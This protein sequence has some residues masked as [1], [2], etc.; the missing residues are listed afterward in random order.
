MNLKDRFLE[1]YKNPSDRWMVLLIPLIAALI[2]FQSCAPSTVKEADPT[3]Y[4][5]DSLI[6]K[7]YVLIPVQL[8]NHQSIESMVGAQSIVNIYAVKPGQSEGQ[9]LGRNLRMVRAPLN[10]QQFAVLVPESKVSRFMSQQGNLQAV[11]QNKV[12]DSSSEVT[13]SYSKKTIQY[14]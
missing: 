4:E 2:V 11:L 7:G 6:P 3:S 14:F 10:P 9:L 8:E 12:Q 5:P 13:S 1:L